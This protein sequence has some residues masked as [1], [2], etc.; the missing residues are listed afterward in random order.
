MQRCFSLKL[1]IYRNFANILNPAYYVVN[2]EIKQW[3]YLHVLEVNILGRVD[4]QR[5][6]PYTGFP[7]L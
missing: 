5:G 3:L 2:Q 4:P 6:N 7:H 1:F